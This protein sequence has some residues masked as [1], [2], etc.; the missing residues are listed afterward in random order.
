MRR[1]LG[2]LMLLGTLAASCQSLYE[3]ASSGSLYGDL[4]EISYTTASNAMLSLDYSKFDA[5]V[6]FHNYENGRGT[7]K[8]AEELS[9]IRYNAFYGQTD[10]KSIV[11]PNSLR[12]IDNNAFTGCT[13]LTDV[14]LNNS[15]YELGD[16]VFEGCTSL[17]TIK[18]PGE[19]VEMGKEV[20]KGC[21]KLSKF[22]GTYTTSNGK[23]IVIHGVL[24][25][26]AIDAH[27]NSFDIP[28][29]ADTIEDGTFYGATKLNT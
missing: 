24:K 19:L 28:I 21:S 27:A 26:Y 1:I 7:I 2:I 15:L 17:T 18:I 9:T 12:V 22:T 25:A 6:V 29:E 3:D 5:S 20:F 4:T 8:F 14:S 23:A 10:L 16:N 11:L 13:R